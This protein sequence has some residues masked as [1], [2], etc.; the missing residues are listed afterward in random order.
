MIVK[1]AGA[2]GSGKTTLV[3]AYMKFIKQTCKVE[4]H[5][6][7]ETLG[8]STGKRWREPWQETYSKDGLLHFGSFKK[9]VVLGR[10]VDGVATGGMDCISNKDVRFTM[11]Q[12]MTGAVKILCLFEGLIVGKTYGAIGELS[13]R[14]RNAPWLYVFMD[15]PFDVCVQRVL[16]R[17]AAAGNTAPYNPE[18]HLRADWRSCWLGTQT[19]VRSAG[20]AVHIVNYK[21]SPAKQARAL[22][23]A[24]LA[25]NKGVL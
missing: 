24:I 6:C 4:I 9:M 2:S 10:Y 13:E 11:I 1:I 18:K 3:R 21:H 15:T 12:R 8:D 25:L 7:E 23:N 14:T 5:S 16:A 19:R 17:R 22:H 20:F